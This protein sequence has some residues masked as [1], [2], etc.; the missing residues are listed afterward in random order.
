MARTLDR[1]DA[2]MN[3]TSTKSQQGQAGN[4]PNQAAA[5]AMADAAQAQQAAMKSSR[6][7]G[8]VPGEKPSSES[9]GTGNGA[10][11]KAD[12]MAVGGLPELRQLN[13]ADWAKLPPK[14]AQGLM[15]AQ[16]EG[17]AG[18]YRAM[19]ETYF[20]VIAEKAKEKGP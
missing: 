4:D 7:G 3:A 5:N 6:Q 12:A 10:A 1:I 13:N 9:Q 19:V 17:M 20:R 14:L 2:A 16:R 11:M 8:N 18:E 15:E